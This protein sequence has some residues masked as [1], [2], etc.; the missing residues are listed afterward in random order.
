MLDSP[1]CRIIA[2]I[3]T[4]HGGGYIN[5]TNRANLQLREITT[6]ISAEVLQGLQHLGLGAANPQVDHIRNIMTSPTAGIDTQELID[7]RPLVKSWDNYIISHPAL[8][9]LSAKF[10]VCFDGGGKVSVCDRPN[11]I[12]FAAVLVEEDVYF[13]LYL[14]S[15]DTGILL[16]PQECLP[17]LATLAEVYL[18][19]IDP[20]SHRKPRL[21]EVINDLGEQNYLQAVQQHLPFSLIKK[22]LPSP[23]ASLYSQGEKFQHLGIHPQSQPDLFYLGVLLPLGRLESWQFRSLADLAAK[24]GSGTLRLTP[25]QNLLIPDIPQVLLAEVTRKIHDLGLDFAINNIKSGLVA[26]SGIRGCAAAA[27]DTQSDALLLAD[28]L[29]NHITLDYPVNIHFSG[30]VK[31]C[32]QHYQSDIAL[33][34]VQIQAD[35]ETVTGYDVYVG[36]SDDQTFGRQ[37]YQNVTFTELTTLI[38]RMIKAYQIKR[39]SPRESFGEFT[40][41]YEIAQLKQVFS[42]IQLANYSSKIPKIS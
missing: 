7:T 1:Q 31:S 20:T 35:N 41:R 39:L 19:C 23:P 18:S 9:G 10:S 42:S 29:A 21:R 22:N 32:A 30:C 37:L 15:R 27:T 26:C 40:N 2:D 33:L 11:D 24:Y 17:V 8:S 36:A 5:V 6:G 13:H 4:Q 12:T 38:E 25:W 28:Y 16:L 14:N 34:G 3:A